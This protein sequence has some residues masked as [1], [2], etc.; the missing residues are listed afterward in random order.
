MEF[1]LKTS[2]MFESL[3]IENEIDEYEDDDELIEE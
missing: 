1:S 3:S 2:N